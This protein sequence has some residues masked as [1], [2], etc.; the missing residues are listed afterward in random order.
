MEGRRH[1]DVCGDE[2]FFK[3][4]QQLRVNLLA[5]LEDCV[6]SFRKRL[7]R[8][9]DSAAEASRELL[10]KRGF[11]LLQLFYRSVETEHGSGERRARRHGLSLRRRFDGLYSFAPAFGRRSRRRNRTRA[12][13]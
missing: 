10:L 5:P 4:V 2:R 12:L 9:G 6:Y 8:G 13:C 1:A 11:L 3:L 7:A